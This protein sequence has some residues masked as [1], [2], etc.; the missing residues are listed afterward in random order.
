MKLAWLQNKYPIES[1]S[2]ATGI[3]V[4]PWNFKNRKPKI[5]I[6]HPLIVNYFIKDILGQQPQ[7]RGRQCRSWSSGTNVRR[8]RGWLLAVVLLLLVEGS[9]C[10]Q[11][12]PI[13]PWR[14]R[15]TATMDN[16]STKNVSKMLNIICQHINVNVI[17]FPT[18]IIQLFKRKF[19]W[20][21][22]VKAFC[23]L[24]WGVLKKPLVI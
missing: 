10:T 24:G 20:A 17:G 8:W 2:Y 11:P 3:S 1:S 4:R 6:F 7:G 5:P 22:L 23:F 19:P 18:K 13:S 21:D 15:V 12:T 9:T 14:V 16:S